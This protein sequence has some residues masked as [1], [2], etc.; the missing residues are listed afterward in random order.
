MRARRSWAE[1]Y[2]SARCVIDRRVTPL[3]S[4]LGWSRALFPPTASSTEFDSSAGHKLVVCQ[5]WVGTAALRSTIPPPIQTISRRGVAQLGAR[6]PRS[7]CREAR[8][9]APVGDPAA[10]PQDSGQEQ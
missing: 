9:G 5:G 6:P 3:E 2:D 4:P 7:G 8:C 10:D 1:E